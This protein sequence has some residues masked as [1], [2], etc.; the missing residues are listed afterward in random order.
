MF[1]S[2]IITSAFVQ[3]EFFFLFAVFTN[4]FIHM[5]QIER[6]G[7]KMDFF[8]LSRSP[9]FIFLPLRV[10]HLFLLPL[11]HLLFLFHSTPEMSDHFL[12][13][14]KQFSETFSI[15]EERLNILRRRFGFL[16][17]CNELSSQSLLCFNFLWLVDF[18]SHTRFLCGKRS[19]CHFINFNGRIA[20]FLGQELVISF[21]LSLKFKTRLQVSICS[22]SLSTLTHT[23]K[24]TGNKPPQVRSNFHRQEVTSIGKKKPPQMWMP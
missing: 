13:V 18:F 1:T 15:R 17:I 4:H 3:T 12:R 7:N 16:L 22:F 10:L 11:T 14:K 9:S 20:Y 8:L 19:K 6:K 23:F 5:F 24:K 2:L 21:N